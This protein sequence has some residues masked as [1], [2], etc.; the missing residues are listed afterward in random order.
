M[1]TT[2]VSLK[3]FLND[4]MPS[5]NNFISKCPL[6]M[7]TSL[8]P[9]TGNL[10]I[11][12][13]N[14]LGKSIDG[15][16][17][18][19][20]PNKEKQLQIKEIK[21]KLE[22]FYPIIYLEKEEPYSP[23]EVEKFV[24]DGMTIKEALSMRKNIRIEKFKVMRAHHRYNELD[25]L[26]LQNNKVLKFKLRFKKYSIPTATFLEK[27]SDNPSSMSKVFFDAFEFKYILR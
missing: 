14:S 18:V 1:E 22:N 6:K 20:D 11:E 21:D 25:C 19:I 27:M 4:F 7:K 2:K 23:D 16:N 12:L 9:E 5:F 17:V 24:N 13:L 15:F 10:Y 26:D 8:V 3:D